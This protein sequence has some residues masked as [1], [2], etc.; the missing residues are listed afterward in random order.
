M[1]LEQITFDS[2][3]IFVGGSKVNWQRLVAHSDFPIVAVD[4]GA[5]HLIDHGLSPQYLC[6]DFDS[7]SDRE[8]ARALNAGAN[9]IPLPD[10]NETD[11]AKALEQFDGPVIYAYGF[12]EGRIDHALD[13]FAQISRHS[14][15][16]IYLIGERDIAFVYPPKGEMSLDMGTRISFWSTGLAQ[17]RQS[18]GLKWTLDGRD[19]SA[20]DMS[21]SN[22]ME[23]DGLM[24]DYAGDPL[25]AICDAEAI[26][27]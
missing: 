13:A 21:I 22:A 25:I 20:F 1:E 2:P 26:K 3:V 19:V 7:V 14:T 24:V 5:N 23:G 10:Q 12:L 4:G 17:V 18:M 11:F 8:K 6:G 16:R 15:R 27:F 9:I